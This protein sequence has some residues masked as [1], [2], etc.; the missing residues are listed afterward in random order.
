MVS[1]A[2]G[3]TSLSSSIE[4]HVLVGL[5]LYPQ[6]SQREREHSR[7]ACGITLVKIICIFQTESEIFDINKMVHESMQSSS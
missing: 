1:R 6:E 3:P 4:C 2:G 7:A 5:F